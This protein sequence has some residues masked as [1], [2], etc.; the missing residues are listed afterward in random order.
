MRLILDVVELF[1]ASFGGLE[2][3]RLRDHL[4]A[5]ALLLILDNFEQ[6]LPAAALVADWLAAAPRLKILV[7]SRAVLRLSGEHDVPVPP[8][9]LP[10]DE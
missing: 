3:D 2:E 8:L 1:G 9:S 4:G 6:L 5:R 7:T 10:V